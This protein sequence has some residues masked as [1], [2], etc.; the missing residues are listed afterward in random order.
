MKHRTR[1]NWRKHN[2]YERTFPTIQATKFLV[3][4]LLILNCTWKD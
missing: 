4:C 3:L 2:T 1:S